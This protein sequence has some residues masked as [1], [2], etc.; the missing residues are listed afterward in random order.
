M[1]PRLVFAVVVLAI[2]LTAP[3]FAHNT[4]D[5]KLLF[6]IPAVVPQTTKIA[7]RGS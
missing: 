6:K 7:V 4:V 2:G 1:K 5:P 3:I